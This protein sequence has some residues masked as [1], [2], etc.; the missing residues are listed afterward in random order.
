MKIIKNILEKYNYKNIIEY[1][2]DDK[3]ESISDISR[4]T[5]IKYFS[6]EENVYMPGLS[7]NKKEEK[8]DMIIE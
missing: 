6:K 1:L 2:I 8:E 7:F 4:T 5:F 3:D